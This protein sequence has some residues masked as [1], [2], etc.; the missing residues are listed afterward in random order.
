MASKA[1]NTAVVKPNLGLYLDRPAIAV[2]PGG[3]QAGL[4]FRIQLGQLNNLNIGWSAW[5]PLGSAITLNGPVTLID[6][7]STSEGNN[8]LVFGTP[9][10]L[11]QFNPSTGPQYLSPIYNTGTASASGTAVTGSSTHWATTPSGNTFQNAKPGD[12]ISFGANNVTSP[13]A[14]WYTIHTVNSDTSITLTASAGSVGSGAYTIRQRFTGSDITTQWQTEVFVDVGSPPTDLLFFT[15]GLDNIVTWDGDDTSATIQSGLN[16]TCKTIRQF[17]DVMVY[18][19][20]VQGGDTLATTII[21]SDAGLPLNAGSASSGIAGQFI[22][23]GGTDP[24]IA[25]E[26]IG[27]YL[28]IYCRETII[29]VQSVGE[30]LVYI[31]RIAV[32]GKGAIATNGLSV[33]PYNHQFIAPDGM[34]VFDGNTAQPVNTHVWREVLS[35]MDKIREGNI[36]T[37]LDEVNG[38]QIWSVPQTSDPNSGTASSPST[39]AWTEHYLEETAGQAQSALIASAMGLNRPYSAR[40][41]PFTAIG[42]FLNA[43]VTIWSQLT[44]AWNTY[45]FR[46]TDSFFSASFPIVL[47]GD[48]NGNLYQLNTAQ[49]A[50]GAS[51]QSFVTFGRKALVDG[52]MRALLRR[53]YPFVTQ[54]PTTLS[55]TCGFSDFASA[56]AQRNPTFTYAQAQTNEDMFFMPVYRRGRY[57]DITLGDVASN[58]WIINGYDIDVLPGGMR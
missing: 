13:G 49:T 40:S 18:G 15:N 58:T 8:F 52:R 1:A 48:N 57:V 35:T 46:W 21:T 31:F 9:T 32:Q 43:S 24:I 41:F 28:A 25:M 39:L 7:F 45:N 33:F 55:M 36:F 37:F 27:A 16:F 54:F 50:N 51:L 11:Y 4:N 23:Q 20:V 17:A 6:L 30:P 44:Q 26:R 47:A 2:P 14:T 38:E 3:L 19:N 53:V 10:D 12:Q 42:N 34:Y 29:V 56:T 22:V 5:K